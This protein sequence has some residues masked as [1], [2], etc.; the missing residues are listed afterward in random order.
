MAPNTLLLTVFLTPLVS[1]ALIALFLRKQGT[2]ASIVSVLACTV[3]TVSSLALVFSDHRPT[4][5]QE[6][7]TL[8][9]LSISLGVKFDDLAAL[10][11]GIVAIVGLCL[12]LFSLG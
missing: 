5:S 10:M 1:A 11:L 9:T 12:D 7:L 2:L 3:V 8:D 4:F 6:W